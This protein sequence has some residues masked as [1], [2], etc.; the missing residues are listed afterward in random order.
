LTPSTQSVDISVLQAAVKFIATVG[1]GDKAIATVKQ[2]SS[3][4][5]KRCRE[6][7]VVGELDT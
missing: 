4:Q 5:I 2:V 3:L 6:N 1:D 7:P